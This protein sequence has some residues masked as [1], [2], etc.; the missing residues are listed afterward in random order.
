MEHID[1]SLIQDFL[2]ESNEL[3]EMLDTELVKLE[4]IQDAN[5][6][7]ELLNGVFRALHTIKG[8]ASFLSMSTLT[9]FAH[10]AE[11]ALNRLRKGEVDIT[12]EVMDAMLRSVDILRGMLEEVAEGKEITAGPQVL[13]DQL[14]AIAEKESPASQA[15]EAVSTPTVPSSNPA[16]PDSQGNDS[17]ASQNIDSGGSI[18]IPLN[19]HSSKADLL[20][21]MAADLADS[22][23][24]IGELLTEISDRSTRDEGAV[25]LAEL[26]PPMRQTADFFELDALT[27]L[28]DL[29]AKVAPVIAGTSQDIYQEL[30]ARLGAIHHLV[31]IQAESLT[32]NVA[33]NWPL[34]TF[35]QRVEMLVD[36]NPLDEQATGQHDNDPRSVLEWDAV[37]KSA[38]S[39]RS[40][41]ETTSPQPVEVATS[42]ANSSIDNQG[43]AGSV[44]Q[45]RAKGDTKD[46]GEAKTRGAVVGDQTVRV[47]VGRLEALL[48]LVGQ[49]VLNKNRII[50]L[51][52]RL[53]DH[54]LP[55]EAI[56]DFTGASS[57]LDRLTGELQVGVMRTRMQPLSKLFDRYPRVIRDMA[58]K[59]GKKLNLEV[60]GKE[61]EVDKTVLEN[62][63]DPL[64]HIL[65]NSADH[66]I[67][68]T[69]TRLAAGKPEMGTIRLSA[70]HQGSHVRV[71]IAD[72]GKGLHRD[73][74]GAKA[75]EKGLV[76]TD[77]LAALS[78]EEVFKFI[79]AAGFSTAAQVTDLSGRGVG[80]DVVRTNIQRLN[81]VINVRSVKGQ[82]T[83]IEVLIPLTVAIMPAMIV[84][85]GKHLYAVPLTTIIEIVRPEASSL[86]S[87]K[88]RP[89]MKLRDKVLPLLDMREKLNEMEEAATQK[90]AVVV[91][92]G[93]DQVGLVVDRLIGQQEIVIKSLD[94]CYATNGPFSGATIREDGGVSLILNVNQLVSQAQ[95][96]E[97][98]A[99]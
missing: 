90:F 11:D 31:Q 4:E 59:T 28:V 21:F 40:M 41:E 1:P 15:S 9:T 17:N 22:A 51:S 67:E 30:Y 19:L 34:E 63:A 43:S 77:Q 42:S 57:E 24:Q 75:V 70:E 99:A 93:Q 39:S 20:D 26:T 12:P 92:V 69:D 71:E 60:A 25:K 72:N 85:V 47:E 44:A 82:G 80:M 10:A 37:L 86:Y 95:G 29:L 13:I 61:T 53:Q 16:Q 81:G 76:T 7:K 96:M 62:L 79:F 56:E 58:R 55:H 35:R 66:G 48:N 52:R 5:E 32:R 68:S 94:D 45:S 2:T 74:I 65:R 78:D 89:V 97:R 91:G 14:H 18:E 49:L 27:C 83:T 54:G 46:S 84:G 23:K 36:G 87:V 33:M 64:V 73:V 98:I 8:A 3:I 6:K 38:E 50:A 88:G